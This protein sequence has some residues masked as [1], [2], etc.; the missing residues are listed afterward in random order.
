VT[1]QQPII[2]RAGAGDEARAWT[3]AK[4]YFASSPIIIPDNATTFQTNLEDPNRFWIAEHGTH[5]VGCVAFRPLPDFPRAGEV[6]RLYVRPTHR[7][8]GVADALMTVLET[9]ARNEGFES[10]YLDTHETFA[11]A[12][13]LYERRGYERIQRY[14]QNP[15]A[16]IFMR[17]DL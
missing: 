17:R 16:T 15:L 1:G 11:A 13:A 2:R 10:L 7:G 14:N 4:E 6:R 8:A 3:I 12:I 5:V 9:S